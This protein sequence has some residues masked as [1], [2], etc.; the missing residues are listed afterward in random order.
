MARFD[1]FTS[2]QALSMAKAV[3]NDA[4]ADESRFIVDPAHSVQYQ[5]AYLDKSQR[6]VN[7]GNNVSYGQYINTAAFTQAVADGQRTAEG[8]FLV[9]EALAALVVIGLVYTGVR[10]RLAEYRD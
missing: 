5:Q 8:E 1:S 10:P 7:V 9:V 4:N 6:I 2:I 3:S